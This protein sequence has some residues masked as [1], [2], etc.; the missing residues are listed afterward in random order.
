MKTVLVIEDNESN[1]YLTSFILTKNGYNV[2]QA[3][4]G[5]KGVRIALK[6]KLDLIL[7]DLQLPNLDGYE[8]IKKIR[9][10]R[11]DCNVPII[12][13]T[14]YA[15]IGD[16]DKALHAGFTGYLK[17]PINPETFLQEIEKYLDV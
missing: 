6:E 3:D 2:L 8:A 5:E 14:S 12:A 9:S 1:M 15:M 10:S 11:M 17:K 4:S 7:M 16:E 13:I